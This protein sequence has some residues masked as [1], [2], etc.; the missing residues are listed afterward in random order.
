MFAGHGK[1]AQRIVDFHRALL[2]PAVIGHTAA[3]LSPQCFPDP[4]T[5]APE[6]WSDPHHEQYHTTAFAPFSKGTHTCV[7]AGIAE[8]ADGT[9]VAAALYAVRLEVY[10]PDYRL[11]T[12]LNP[13]PGPESQFRMRVLEQRSHAAARKGT[14]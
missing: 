10:P 8:T 2:P 6:R 5:F 14:Q 13:L 1:V 4:V 9:T 3:H 11:R 12:T 7:G